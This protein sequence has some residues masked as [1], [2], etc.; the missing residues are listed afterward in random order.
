[1]YGTCSGGCCPRHKQ[2]VGDMR[3]GRLNAA[4]MDAMVVTWLITSGDT[5]RLF[6]SE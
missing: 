1:M 6:N 5:F 2:T 3:L 4:V